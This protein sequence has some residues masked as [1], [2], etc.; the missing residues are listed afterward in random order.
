MECWPLAGEA[1]SICS[2]ARSMPSK[3]EVDGGLVPVGLG[4]PTEPAPFPRLL[5]HVLCSAQFNI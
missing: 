1:C 5:L 2:L 3:E 4:G